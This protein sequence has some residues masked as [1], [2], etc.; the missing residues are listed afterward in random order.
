MAQ[1]HAISGLP[2]SGSTLLAALLRQNPRFRAGIASPVHQLVVAMLDQMNP[3]REFG[4]FFD[5]CRRRSI[6]QG[7]FDAC[8]AGAGDDQVIFDSNRM[9][10]GHTALLRE[11]YP[12]LRIICCVR[13]IG[14]IINSIERMLRQNPLQT[15]RLFDFKAGASFYARVQGLM[16]TDF[17]NVGL[18]LGQLREAWFSEHADML[19]VVRYESLVRDPKSILARLYQE[20]GEPPFDHDFEAL[21]FDEPQYDT[22]LGMPGLHKVAP[23]VE[24]LNREPIIPPEIFIKYA[25]VAF[26]TRAQDNPR[27]VLVL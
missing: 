7:L 11:L 16:H 3:S 12:K 2:R 26:W 22:L 20:L 17:G 4:G 25:D 1:V 9:W 6:L 18:A 8:Y 19:I 5:P 23:R 21:A 27:Q 24:P 10:T 14:W 13:E 15:S